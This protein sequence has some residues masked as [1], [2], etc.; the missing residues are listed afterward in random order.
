MNPFRRKKQLPAPR[1]RKKLWGTIFE[2]F[3]GAWQRNIEVKMDDVMAYWA[4]YACVRLISCDVGKMALQLQEKT[5]DGIWK[6]VE[7]NSPY[8]QVLRKPNRYQQTIKFLEYWTTSKLYHGNTYALKG[9]D[10]RGIVTSLHILSPPRVRTLVAPNGDVYYELRTDDLAGVTQDTVTVP[11]REIIHDRMTCLHHPLVGVSPIYACGVAATHG[12][13]IQNTSARFFAAGSMPGGVLTAPGPIDQ[14]DADEIKRGWD[15]NYSGDNAG[16][17]AV[18]GDGMQYEPMTITASDSQMIEQLR[19]TAIMVASTFGVP[20]H[21]IGIGDV[22]AYNNAA[23]MDQQYYSQCLQTLAENI[24]ASLDEGLDLPNSE[25]KHYRIELDIT[26]LIR[27]DPDA[28]YKA[29]GEAI[30]GSWM[31]PNEARLAEN[32]PPVAGG[33]SPMIQQQNYSLAAIAAR[34]EV[35]DEPAGDIVAGALEAISEQV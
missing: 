9:R 22:P 26:D 12:L 1:K 5:K 17:V 31:S 16:K 20:P 8:W 6:N 7:R 13:A 18:L 35:R 23:I 14:E 4:V 28:R 27:L 21:K 29:H 25:G 3:A 34:D 19:M 2:S 15:I 24:E 32:M 30:R 11:A 33:D 10:A